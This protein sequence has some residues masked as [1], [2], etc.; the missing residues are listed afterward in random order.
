MKQSLMRC[1]TAVAMLL[2]LTAGTALAQD[3]NDQPDIVETAINADGFNTLVTALQEAELVSTLQG[4]G[5]FTVFAPTDEAFAALPEGTLESLLQPENRDQLVNILTYHVVPGKVMASDV[6][7]LEEANTVA[8]SA[9]SIQV[10]DGN[11]ML[12]G[13]NTAQVVQTDIEASNG[14]I[15]VIDTVLMP[16]SDEGM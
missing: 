8:G 11:V 1:I 2:M 5:P 14:V 15:H 10:S 16:P 4:E 9:I 7:Q 3:M 12:T 13:D 6:T